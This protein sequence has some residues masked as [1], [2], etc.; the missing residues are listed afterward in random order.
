MSAPVVPFCV[1]GPSSCQ[2]PEPSSHSSVSQGSR[3]FSFPFPGSQP[4][5]SFLSFE[6]TRGVSADGDEFEH[7]R[8]F[9]LPPNF[10]TFASDEKVNYLASLLEGLA[11]GTAEQFSVVHQ[12][13]ASQQPA[14]LPVSCSH[15]SGR[16]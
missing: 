4:P 12:R 13:I 14:L 8:A 7:I 11:R 16:R 2:T 9:S 1:A 6:C 15:A 3:P 5:G 10:A